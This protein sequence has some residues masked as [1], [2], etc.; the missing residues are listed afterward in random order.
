MSLH[1]FDTL[2]RPILLYASDFWGCLKQP[3]NNPIEKIHLRF[4][5]DLLGVQKQTV[6]LGVYLELGRTPLNILG[7]KLCVKNWKRIARGEAS[8]IV[9]KSYVFNT[10][11]DT[12]WGRAIKD[13]VSRIGLMTVFGNQTGN[14]QIKSYLREKAI[15]FARKHS[16][17]YT[18]YQNLERFQY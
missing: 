15:F 14:P 5:K 9:N 6:N 12:G 8:D 2:I 3:K 7:N 13:S 4:C 10:N 11:N 1:L 18:M 17:K 16:H